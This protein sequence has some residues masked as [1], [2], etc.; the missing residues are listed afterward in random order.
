MKKN[1][2]FGRSPENKREDGRCSPHYFTDI[3]HPNIKKGLA[4]A[5]RQLGD[6]EL[7]SLKVCSVDKDRE[8]ARRRALLPVIP[9]FL[10]L[11]SRRGPVGWPPAEVLRRKTHQ[12]RSRCRSVI[13][14]DKG[15]PLYG[16]GKNR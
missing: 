2:L 3:V 4:K 5:G 7:C 12:Q 8:R 6:I 11:A 1:M 14:N 13:P 15:Y 10:W 9:E 16:F